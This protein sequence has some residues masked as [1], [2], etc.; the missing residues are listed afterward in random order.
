MNYKASHRVPKLFSTLYNTVTQIIFQ[1]RYN[2]FNFKLQKAL[3]GTFISLKCNICH[4]NKVVATL[5]TDTKNI[6]MISIGL[7]YLV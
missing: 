5:L 6:Q 7:I 3:K 2:P 4:P 1:M